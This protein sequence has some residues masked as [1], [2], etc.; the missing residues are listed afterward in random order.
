MCFDNHNSFEKVSTFITNSCQPNSQATP[1]GVLS[2]KS[3]GNKFIFRFPNAMVFNKKELDSGK[4]IS[5]RLAFARARLLRLV[6]TFSD[7][8]IYLID[9]I[10]LIVIR[11]NILK[12]NSQKLRHSLCRMICIFL[13]LYLC[14]FQVFIDG[15]AAVALSFV[16][17]L[18]GKIGIRMYV[19]CWWFPQHEPFYFHRAYQMHIVVYIGHM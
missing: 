10:K 8:D 7:S 12:H 4:W 17:C 14:R 11:V 5:S 15:E 6:F 19:T 3:A 18:D 2:R 1:Y 13:S 16:R 9:C